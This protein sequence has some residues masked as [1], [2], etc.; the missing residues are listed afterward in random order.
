MSA[1]HPLGS[2][3]QDAGRVI[4]NRQDHALA[5]KGALVSRAHP[6]ASSASD[7]GNAR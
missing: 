1:W 2:N 4:D 5:I 7:S 6:S 3:G